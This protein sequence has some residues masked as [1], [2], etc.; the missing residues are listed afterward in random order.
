MRVGLLPRKTKSA[1]LWG[2]SPMKSRAT[3]A[4]VSKLCACPGA[5]CT[6]ESGLRREASAVSNRVEEAVKCVRVEAG[7]DADAQPIAENELKRLGRNDNA[8][9]R[10]RPSG[11]RD[12]FNKLGA[13]RSGCGCLPGPKPVEVPLPVTKRAFLD[14]NLAGE[15]SP[16]QTALCPLVDA[17]RPLV[18]PCHARSCSAVPLARPD[19]ARRTDTNRDSTQP[20]AE[21]R[22]LSCKRSF[23]ELLE[24]LAQSAEKLARRQDGNATFPVTMASATPAT[25][26]NI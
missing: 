11:R 3:A 9:R 13:P 19:G 7:G 16:A 2:S 21:V 20:D 1:P 26:M 25:A 18:S 5:W 6:R 14:A 4:R 15:L 8:R 23:K 22:C 12:Q 17:L 10:R 24:C